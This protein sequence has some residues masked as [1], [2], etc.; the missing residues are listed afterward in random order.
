MSSSRGLL[1][2]A[3]HEGYEAL[4]YAL[5]IDGPLDPQAT[6]AVMLES[7]PADAAAQVLFLSGLVNDWFRDPGDDE[8][9][10]TL[11]VY[12]SSDYSVMFPPSLSRRGRTSMFAPMLKKGMSHRP[13]RAEFL[14]SLSAVEGWGRSR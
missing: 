3:T 8:I 4:P 11:P 6:A 13:G 2:L 5:V 7:S 12:R 9:D 14:A 1:W 10:W